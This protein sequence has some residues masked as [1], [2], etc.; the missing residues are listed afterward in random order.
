MG[1]VRLVVHGHFYQPP[2][3]NPWTDEV[4]VEPSAA[5]FHDWNERVCTESYRPNG[6]A[7]VIDDRGLVTDI[8][9]NYEFLSFDVGPTLLSWLEVHAPDVYSR[10]R[11]ADAVGGGA[12]AQAYNHMILPLA[13]GRDLRTQVRWGLADFAHRFGRRAEGM[14]LPEAAVDDDVL[15]VL[16][17]EGVRFTIL[18]PGQAARSR[19]LGSGLD[20]DALGGDAVVGGRPYRWYHPAGDGRC[21]DIVF[22]DGAISHDLAFGL[23]GLSSQDLVRRVLDAGADGSPV[24]VATDGETFG[25][26]HKWAD[27]A[28]AYAFTYE[29][30]ANGVEVVNAATLVRDTGATH[31]VQ[32]RRSSWSCEHS[33]GRWERDCGCS[34]GGEP[35]WDQAWR[36]PLRAALDVVRDHG[37]SVFER[38]GAEV[39]LD[40]WA[41]RDAYVD[42]VLGRAGTDEF[43]ATHGR[44]GIG[45]DARV[46][47]LAL[48]EAQRQAMSMYTSCGWFFNDLAGIETV[49]VLRYAAR[50]IDLLDEI[51]EADGLLD[52]FATVLAQAHSNDRAEGSGTDIWHRHVEPTRVDAG[53]VAAHVGLVLLL[54]GRELARAGGYDV[55]GHRYRRAERGGLS[56][57]AGRVDLVHHRTGR[58]AAYV[59]AGLHL[60]GLEVYGAL[61]AATDA[62]DADL[63]ERFVAAVEGAGRVTTLLRL[64]GDAFGPRE[65]GL[66]SAL[67]DAAGQ[68]VASAVDGMVERFGSTYERLYGEHRDLL[69][70]LLTA[71]FPVPEELRAPARFVLAR[72]FEAEIVAAGE[73]AV[74]APFRVAEEILAEARRAGFGLA[75]PRVTAVLGRTLRAAVAGV[76]DAPHPDRLQAALGLLQLAREVGVDIDVD[77]VQELVHAAA[78]RPDA[79][80]L[81][82]LAEALGLAP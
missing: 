7:R 25:H 8:V 73:G 35:G 36:S 6:W 40:P 44:G 45:R 78:G 58:A 21:V 32:V 55:V 33:V 50:T 62:E 64:V 27:R 31:E 37:I 22:Y 42:V 14:W 46:V 17:D 30:G 15:A 19:P 10:M 18:A 4:P 54:E 12:M 74:L 48:L 80:A 65:F 39:L 60:G 28:L 69:G 13:N 29:A 11:E 26:H 53:R 70:A 67:P 63:V 34:T 2:R 68:I 71:R 16:A 75:T 52:R 66:D 23:S 59:Y 51:G 57:L 77:R 41:A 5:P 72:R 24:C 20:W 1:G 9:D 56:G 82:P 38:R 81:R 47:A 3:E 79:G 61:R 76:I 43:L 49:Q